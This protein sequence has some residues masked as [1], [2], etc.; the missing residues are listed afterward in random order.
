MH[1]ALIGYGVYLL[2]RRIVARKLTAAPEEA[3]ERTVSPVALAG[4]RALIETTRAGGAMTGFFQANGGRAAAG[5]GTLSPYVISAL[6]DPEVQLSLGRAATAGRSAFD[7]VTTQAPREA[8][9][10]V[11]YDSKVHDALGESARQLDAAVDAIGIKVRKRRSLTKRFLMLVGFVALVAG[12]AIAVKHF[13]GGGEDEFAPEV[14][15]APVDQS[16]APG[17]PAT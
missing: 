11:A 16:E 13:L 9:H 4:R 1:K 8:L 6:R 17:P 14:D 3:K 10:A 2:A 7:R 12:A 15:A 5:I